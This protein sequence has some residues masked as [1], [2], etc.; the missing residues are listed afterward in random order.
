M[1]IKNFS[2]A[3]YLFFILCF[4]LCPGLSWGQ[5]LKVDAASARLLI[6]QYADGGKAGYEFTYRCF[7][8]LDKN[9]LQTL[10]RLINEDMEAGNGAIVNPLPIE[11]SLARGVLNAI[12]ERLGSLAWDRV[13]EGRFIACEGRASGLNHYA[14]AVTEEKPAGFRA[15]IFPAARKQSGVTLADFSAPPTGEA[16]PRGLRN[17]NP[18]NFRPLHPHFS[19]REIL[20]DNTVSL[21]VSVATLMPY[22]GYLENPDDYVRVFIKTYQHDGRI[23]RQAVK[24]QRLAGGR[25]N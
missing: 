2:A 19:G 11:Q 20:R 7:T 24:I 15:G 4:L 1:S 5:P 16:A 10:K 25:E 13:L 17:N 18:A 12:D 8:A 6:Y 23:S 14:F 21:Y 3:I 9:A 22:Y